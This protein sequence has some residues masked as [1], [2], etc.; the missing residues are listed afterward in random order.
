MVAVKQ[1]FVAGGMPD[2]TY[3]DRQH[4]SLEA[5]LRNELREGYKIVAITGPTKSGKTVLCKK[6]ISAQTSIWIDGGQITD[7]NQFWSTIIGELKLP[8]ETTEN[9]NSG[10]N[11]SFKAIFGFQAQISSGMSLK[12]EGQSK[13][14]IL[15]AMRALGYTLIVDD[16]HYLSDTV[17][18]DVVRSLKSEIFLGL[19]VVFIAVPHRVFDAITAEPEMEGRYAHISIPAWNLDDLMQIPKVGFPRLNMN[20]H[21]ETLRGTSKNCPEL[22]AAV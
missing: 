2:I 7:S 9:T 18:I 14:S 17:Q 5:S 4:L 3:V 21:P 11:A 1:V 10:H 6:V 13:K 15:S 12:F 16:F 19:S 20:V 8:S 22:A